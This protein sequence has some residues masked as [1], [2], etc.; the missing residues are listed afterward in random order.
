LDGYGVHIFVEC[1]ITLVEL[2]PASEIYR[3][4]LQNERSFID[5]NDGRRVIGVLEV[6]YKGGECIGVRVVFEKVI[7]VRVNA[8]LFV[9]GVN[10][11]SDLDFS[12]V[13]ISLRIEVGNHTNTD[14]PASGTCPEKI[15]E[16]TELDCLF[17]MPL[18]LKYS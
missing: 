12:R 4:P 5:R 9:L 1:T 8:V 16:M 11:G 3:I 2:L 6:I 15:C 14:P 18:E 10:K 17:W 7:N 13:G